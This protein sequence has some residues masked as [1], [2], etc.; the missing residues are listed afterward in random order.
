MPAAVTLTGALDR[1]ALRHALDAIVARHE[2]LRTS[3]AVVEGSPVQVIAAA[4][5]G[6]A[7]IEHDLRALGAGARALE[8]ERWSAHEAHAAFDLSTGPLIRARL[9]ILDDQKQIL[10]VTQHHIVSDGWSIGV[11]VRELTTLYA[12]FLEGVGDTLPPLTVQYADYARWERGRMNGEKL[13]TQVG[14]WRSQ[15]RGAPALL[16]L[17]TDRP[18]PSV[19]SH[20]GASVSIVLPSVL[21]KALRDL[22]RRH[23][24]T[25]FMTLLAG[26]SILMA[27]L[28]G[29]E[30]VVVGTPV[31]NR[32]RQE[33]EPMV[34]L[35]VNTL[36]M[37]VRVDPGQTVSQLLAQVKTTAL[38]AFAHQALPFDQIVD[39]AMPPRSLAHNAVFQT[40]LTLDTTPATTLA[41]P[42]LSLQLG[43]VARSSTQ[44]DLALS[45]REGN[46]VLEGLLEYATDLFD[47]A[48]VQRWAEHLQILWS[49][50]AEDAASSVAALPMQPEHARTRMLQDFNDTGLVRD[51]GM[52]LHGYFEAQVR[53]NGDAVALEFEDCQ[54]SYSELNC[55][56]NRLAH[57]LIAQGV[58]PDDRVAVCLRR[59]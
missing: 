14:F 41:L 54:L 51:E 53:R 7:L 39:A 34:G 24:T 28:S 17:P 33:F 49:A 27:R 47:Q 52:L 37:R 21:T 25:V 36:P 45:L 10:L 12:G 23:G 26:W 32:M 15:L 35:F 9:L 2:V 4:D 58:G 8:A 20:A 6:I 48:T 11:L 46:D 40:M 19:Q 38:D 16:E 1:I 31:A 30:D 5:V 3:F 56:A 13:E 59:G 43:A 29:Q 42:G 22:S 18:R 44:F 50:M 55:R 57:R